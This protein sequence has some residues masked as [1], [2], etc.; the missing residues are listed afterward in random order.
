MIEENES[1]EED[2]NLKELL[3]EEIY[4]L[5]DDVL[6]E[7]KN[8]QEASKMLNKLAD[9]FLVIDEKEQAE[10]CIRQALEINPKD[11]ESYRKL[12]RVRTEKEK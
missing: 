6:K 3:A 12:V 2:E 11:L 10:E 8:N 5:K 4:K 1:I 9:T 7:G